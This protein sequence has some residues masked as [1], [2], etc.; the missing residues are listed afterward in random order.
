MA[1][2]RKKNNVRSNLK[3]LIEEIRGPMSEKTITTALIVGGMYADLLTPQDTGNLLR[4]RFREVVKSTNGWIGKYGYTANYAAAVHGAS[5]KL[6][7]QPRAHFGK[8]KA[9]QEFGGGTQKGN[10]WDPNAEP[11][12]LTK[13]FE[14][15]GLAKI[16]QVI[17]QGMS[18]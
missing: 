14:R 1:K 13:G 11:E 10:Y 5:G 8:T 16:K 6:K 17:I 12:F 9:G 3:K 15:D 2:P 18:I 4:S 7:G